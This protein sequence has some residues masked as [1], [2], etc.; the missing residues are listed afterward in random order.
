MHVELVVEVVTD[1][2]FKKKNT[3]KRNDKKGRE[4]RVIMTMVALGH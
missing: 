4:N 3:M 2:L 1:E